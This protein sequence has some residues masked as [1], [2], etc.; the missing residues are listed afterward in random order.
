MIDE[1]QRQA[2]AIQHVREAVFSVDSLD[3]TIA[4][5]RYL[6]AVNGHAYSD[7]MILWLDGGGALCAYSM[8]REDEPNWRWETM[9]RDPTIN[10]DGR[11][12]ATALDYAIEVAFAQRERDRRVMRLY[13]E[14][15]KLGYLLTPKDGEGQ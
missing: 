10:P 9:K 1:T 8:L 14:A 15:G 3:Q 5:A 6:G 12:G 7:S 11:A 13:E 2:V 4:M